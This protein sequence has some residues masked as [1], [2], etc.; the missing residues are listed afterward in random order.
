MATKTTEKITAPRLKNMKRQGEKL[1]MLTCYDATFAALLNGTSLDCVLVGDSLGM[2]IQGQK[3]TLPVTLSDMI[4]HTRAVARVLDKAHLCADMPFMSYQASRDEAIKNAGQLMKRGRAESVKLEG[5][6]E[7]ADLVERLV[8]IG[9]PVLGHIGLTPQSVHQMGGYK[10]QGKTKS[11]E[12][13]LVEDAKALENAGAWGVVLEG[14]P[15]EV[16][17]RITQAISIPT[18]GIASGP[19][20]DGQ[21]LV[22]Y[23]LLGLNLNFKPRFVKRYAEMGR[24]VVRAVKNYVHEVQAGDFPTEAHSFHRDI[25]AI[26]ENAS[27]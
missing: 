7:I 17:R 2:V 8:K 14:V 25:S 1:T 12:N 5:G 21:V 4:Y 24:A 10:I 23:D 16:A 18:V 27:H 26:K 19:H 22:I 3:T 6:Q 13:K 20:C 11:Q 9:I 15:M